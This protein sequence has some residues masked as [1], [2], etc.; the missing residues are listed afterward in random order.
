MGEGLIL[1]VR[2]LAETMLRQFRKGARGRI[3]EQAI[4]AFFRTTDGR[5]AITRAERLRTCGTSTK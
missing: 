1:K 2:G 3:A 4:E 5:A